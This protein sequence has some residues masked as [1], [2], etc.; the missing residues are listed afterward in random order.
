M[1]SSGASKGIWSPSIGAVGFIRLQF[2]S[3]YTLKFIILKNGEQAKVDDE[4]FDRL[5]RFK[6]QLSTDGYAKTGIW[7]PDTKQVKTV[8]M[9]WMVLNFPG[10]RLDH[11]NQDK[12]DNQKGNLRPATRTQNAGNSKSRV[13][14][15][16]FK[17]VSLYRG[18]RWH[19]QLMTTVDGRAVCKHLGYFDEE[20]QAAKAYDKAAREYFGEFA[21]TN[22]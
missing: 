22:Y 17:G 3:N 21:S 14:T 1:S 12:L 5:A 11:H 2:C 9:H 18:R 13:G 15:S 8:L 16:R 6:W 20:E 19:A 10:F 7:I 4:D